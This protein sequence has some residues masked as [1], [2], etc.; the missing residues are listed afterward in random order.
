M[1]RP[2]LHLCPLLP[3]TPG[4]FS[5]ERGAF[6]CIIVCSV[7]VDKMA[8]RGRAQIRRRGS[9]LDFRARVAGVTELGAWAPG[10]PAA[11]GAV[12]F[13]GLGGWG[14]ALRG[15]ERGAGRG[16]LWAGV[17]GEPALPCVS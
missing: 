11:A 7:P 13:C 9:R 3:D 5:F 1:A 12:L 4:T 6:V 15:G 17:L 8:R 14:P 2:F 16:R 10:Q